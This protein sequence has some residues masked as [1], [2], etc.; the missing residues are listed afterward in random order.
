[1]SVK[2]RLRVDRSI[3]SILRYLEIEIVVRDEVTPLC[4]AIRLSG[5]GHGHQASGQRELSKPVFYA[6]A[7]E[8]RGD[9]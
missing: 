4:I 1:M 3:S 8:V 7:F 6:A 2:K 9:S 5:H